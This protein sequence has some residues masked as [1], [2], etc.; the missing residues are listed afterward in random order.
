VG[1]EYAVIPVAFGALRPFML[2]ESFLVF[3]AVEKAGSASMT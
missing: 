1:F 3:A 2:L